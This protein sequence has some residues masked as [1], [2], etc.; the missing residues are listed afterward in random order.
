MVAI[1]SFKIERFPTITI[2][3][4]LSMAFAFGK[5]N[6]YLYANAS[7]MES[8]VSESSVGRRLVICC[9]NEATNECHTRS[10]CNDSDAACASNK[11]QSTVETYSWKNTSP[12]PPTNPPTAQPTNPQ[13]PSP[14]CSANAFNVVMSIFI[15]ECT[16]ILLLR[17]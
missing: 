14:V 8:S 9:V 16:F 3:L 13:T 2:L 17:V 1:A 12:P 6:P 10:R 5:D 7:V 15:I 11:C 4:L